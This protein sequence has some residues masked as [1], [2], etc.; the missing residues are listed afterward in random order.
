M[1]IYLPKS[2]NETTGKRKILDIFKVRLETIINKSHP[3]VRVSEAINRK[4]LGEKLTKKYLERMVA[5]GKRMQIMVG[6][7]FGTCL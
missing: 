1:Q 6:L 7:Q 2:E 5:P 4:S 3:L